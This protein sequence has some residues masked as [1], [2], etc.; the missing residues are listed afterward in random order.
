VFKVLKDSVERV[1]R[2]P[3]DGE[4]SVE[5]PLGVYVV[6]GE[7]VCVVGGVDEAMDASINWAEVKGVAI[8]TTKH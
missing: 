7:T 4:P 8:G 1:L 3:E 2:S 5:V 6:R